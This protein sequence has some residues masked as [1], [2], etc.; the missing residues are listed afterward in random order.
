[1]KKNQL[2]LSVLI[3][4]LLASCTGA[5][6]M[7]GPEITD[8]EYPAIQFNPVVLSASVD[9]TRALTGT[10][11]TG[12]FPTGDHNIGVYMM[13]AGT[14]NIYTFD[15][16]GVATPGTQYSNV[17]AT[18]SAN[19]NANP[20][21]KWTQFV[22][23]NGTVLTPANR[24]TFGHASVSV[25][26][27]ADFYAYYPHVA[28]TS[29]NQQVPITNIPFTLSTTSNVTDILYACH[30]NFSYS[31]DVVN[32]NP[33]QLDFRHALSMI[34]F[35][36]INQGK[37]D[38]M[39][40]GGGV[41]DVDGA[42]D[43]FVYTACS[44]NLYSAIVGADGTDSNCEVT[45]NS[46]GTRSTALAANITVPKNGGRSDGDIVNITLPYVEYN[47]GIG[48][49]PEIRAYLMI[50]YAT[51][52]T[53]GFATSYGTIKVPEV[54][55]GTGVYGFQQGYKYSYEI[56]VT[57]TGITFSDVKIAEWENAVTDP[58]VII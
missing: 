51:S 58:S 28:T 19:R 31:S 12:Y 25:G 5:D 1:M 8:P 39:V 41:V 40:S 13:K 38:V 48:N 18:L 54:G 37:E 26:L 47:L 2:Y 6:E 14:D 33:V 57:S 44:M 3:T 11:G 24:M 20:V 46:P 56:T 15:W 34:S 29:N 10:D 45:P 9:Q 30:K 7:S 23:Y 43:S 16:E 32:G 50:S 35:T 49:Q 36:V 4:L 55:T 17:R 42:T 53:G 27:L 21:H 22:Q 52:S